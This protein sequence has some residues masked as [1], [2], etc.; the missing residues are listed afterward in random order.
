MTDNVNV[1]T[2][3]GAVVA[4]DDVGGTHYQ[5]VKLDGGGDGASSAIPGGAYGLYVQGPAPDDSAVSG[6]P[7]YIGGVAASAVTN[8]AVG[9]LVP[10]RMDLHG[11]AYVQVHESLP[12]GTNN[13]GK[14][15]LDKVAG[16]SVAIDN[17]TA[18]TSLRVTL[19][20]DS[21]GQVK[22]ANTAAV[23][24]TVSEFITA[25]TFVVKS[26]DLSGS[27]TSGEVWTPGSNKKFVITDLIV[28]TS[29][30]GTFELYDGNTNSAAY[31]VAKIYLVAYGGAVIN[32]SKPYQS[33]ANNNVLRYASTADLGGSLT[34]SGYEV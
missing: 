27:A 11:C 31:R 10:L 23:S 5:R 19:A 16:A 18:A 33:T 2:G 20:S 9:D 14:I 1:T 12:A 7:V 32:Y 25:Q 24:G 4:T 28:S 29:G 22:I 34:V 15:D 3:V 6:N 26:V 30:V 13:I 8:R 17:G 21:T